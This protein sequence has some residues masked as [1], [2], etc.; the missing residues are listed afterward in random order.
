MR[1]GDG[2]YAAGELEAA[3]DSWEQAHHAFLSGK[4][5]IG[6]AGAAARVAMH[7]LIDTGLIAPVRTWIKRAERLLEGAGSTPV[8]AGLG[9]ARAYE[10]LFSGDFNEARRWAQEAI[11]AGGEH[12]EHSAAAMARVAQA[13]CYIFEGDVDTGLRLL[14]EASVAL[15]SA[16]VDHLTM[17]MTYCEIVCAW[18][19]LAMFDL[20]E[21]WTDVME[22]FSH[23][24]AIGS[25][26]GRCAIHRAQILRLR[27]ES[28]DAETEA[29]AA[30]ESLRPYMRREFGWPLTELGA[31]RLQLGDLAGAEEA[32]L[33]AHEKGWDP[34]P[35]LALLRLAQGD[36]GAAASLIKEA[37]DRP[38]N[39]L[40]KELPPNNELRR[41]PLL[42]AQVEIAIADGDLDTAR[43][44]SDELGEISRGFKSR[45]LEAAASLAI[46]R[47]RLAEGAATEAATAFRTAVHIWSEISAPYEVALAR[48]GLGHAY[49]AQ[50]FNEG[51]LLEFKAARVAFERTGSTEQAGL[52]AAALGEGARPAATEVADNTF[53]REGDYWTIA[54]RGEAVLLRDM[55][56]LH[57]MAHL[58]AHPGREF[59]ALDLVAV[60]RKDSAGQ[61]PL[62]DYELSYST[63]GDA[64]E[65]LDDR[66][67]E[68]Y[69]RRLADIDEDI[70]EARAFGDALRVSS[71]EV[72]RD[73]LLKELSRAVGL[74]GRDRRAGAASER[75]RA[76]VTRAIRNALGKISQHHTSLGEHLDR[77]VRTGTFCAYMPDP[78]SPIDWTE[79]GSS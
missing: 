45:A 23:Q 1:D 38:L 40:S 55:K 48:M 14:E 35:G 41:A 33:L 15:A 37:L 39:L 12:G 76:A 3:F 68:V 78:H 22:R 49:R 57:Y 31:I 42:E 20:A 16:D 56:G 26:G 73:F 24:H 34:Q 71:A 61:T 64:G 44:A 75:A 27:G 11:D 10:R 65:L 25:V 9:L 4:D 62:V 47:A 70:E 2:A 36:I 54:F 19:S 60:V 8:H 77:T 13:R 21:Q 29:L 5:K 30:C 32:F 74:D 53:R 18:Q 79:A 66:S 43:Q 7:L 59:H 72:E 51:A 63:G 67:K 17:G 6:A 46:G 69:R 50:G 58:L 52:A 28:R